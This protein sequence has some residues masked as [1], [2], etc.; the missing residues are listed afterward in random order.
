M[1]G[2]RCELRH[3]HELRPTYTDQSWLSLLLQKFW[4]NHLLASLEKLKLLHVAIAKCHTYS[5]IAQIHT[6]THTYT[7]KHTYTHTYKYTWANTHTYT[8]TYTCTHTNTHHIHTYIHKYTHKHKH[9]HT[10]TQP[11]T[12]IHVHVHVHTHINHTWQDRFLN[13]S[14]WFTPPQRKKEKSNLV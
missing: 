2:H 8:H 12:H 11:H 5:Y 7:H 4:R 14:L 1:T 10:Q 9:I 3:G 13:F 6:Y